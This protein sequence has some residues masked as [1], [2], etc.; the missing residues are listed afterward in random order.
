MFEKDV[1]VM[2]KQRSF[3]GCFCGPIGMEDSS[4]FVRVKISA[5]TQESLNSVVQI[6]MDYR[7]PL[8]EIPGMF[9]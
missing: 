3:G 4:D 7:P 6:L 2:V 9:D 8:E 5:E 1:V